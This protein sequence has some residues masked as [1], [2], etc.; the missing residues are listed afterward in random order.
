MAKAKRKKN[1]SKKTSNK[2]SVS[3]KNKLK[4]KKIAEKQLKQETDIQAKKVAAKKVIKKKPSKTK[5]SAKAEL[6]FLKETEKYLK[7]AKTAAKRRKARKK[8]TKQVSFFK[9]HLFAFDTKALS[10]V[11]FFIA[12]FGAFSIQALLSESNGTQNLQANIAGA[13]RSSAM[14]AF[15]ISQNYNIVKINNGSYYVHPGETDAQIFAFAIDNKN[16]GLVMKEL[17]LSKIGELEDNDFV[18]AKLYE[19]GNVISEATIHENEFYFREF[20]SSIQESTYKEYIVKVD[21]NAELNAG[22]RFK[23]EIKSP[24]DIYLLQGE[25][26]MRKL[27][28]YPIEGNFV[29]T[30]GWRR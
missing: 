13:T 6:K 21:M 1:V 20:S 18:T 16:T 28:H 27:D 19:G 29:T 15:E 25:K 17:R 22:A 4:K 2:K 5:L 30:V 11:A 3:Q 7:N 8:A 12:I 10:I 23:F 24:Y 14:E 26:S 9:K